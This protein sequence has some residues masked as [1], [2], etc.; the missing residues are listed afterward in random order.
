MTIAKAINAV[1]VFISIYLTGILTI[2]L[3]LDYSAAENTVKLYKIIDSSVVKTYFM[4]F[5][6]GAM[7]VTILL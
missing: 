7:L 5:V 2:G 6:L 4:P 1:Q 3:L